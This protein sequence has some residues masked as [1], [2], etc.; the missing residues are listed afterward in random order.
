MKTEAHSLKN[1][2]IFQDHPQIVKWGKVPDQDKVFYM[3]V[4]EE[5]LFNR[6][7]KINLCVDFWCARLLF[8]DVFKSAN[9]TEKKRQERALESLIKVHLQPISLFFY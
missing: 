3:M 6:N 5:R 8:S 1:G 9:Q 2:L 4:L 7:I